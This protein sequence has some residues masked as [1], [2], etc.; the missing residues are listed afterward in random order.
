MLVLRAPVLR[1]TTLYRI[2]EIA[3]YRGMLP[4]TK[5]RLI[6]FL[7]TQRLDPMTGRIEGRYGTDQVDGGMALAE[8]YAWQFGVGPDRFWEDLKGVKA[9]GLAEQVVKPAPGRRAVY[10]LVLR[11]DAI[12][13]DLPEDLMRELRV[14]D[15]PEAE[16][17][18][19][20]AAYGH[21][22]ARPAPA[23]EP[24]VVRGENRET[25]QL[26]TELA[27]APLWEHP[28]DS[29]AAAVAEELRTQWQRASRAVDP[30]PGWEPAEEPQAALVAPA[31]VKPAPAPDLR[32][33]AVADRD[34]AAEM[35]ARIHRL[36][37]VG[38]NGKTSPLYARGFSQ[39]DGFTSNG[40]KWLNRDEEM[41][42]AETTPSAATGKRTGQAFGDDLSSVARS[43]MRRVWH[44][45]RVQLGRGVV[46]LPSGTPE[47]LS[48]S[49]TGDA[50]S[51]LHHTITIALR[52]STESELVDL[53][54][55][56]IVR[57][58]EWGEITFRAENLGRLAGWRLW[59]L[60]NS[61]KNAHGHG[62]RREVKVAAHVQV[63]DEATAEERDRI[64]NR[65]EQVRE[66][67]KQREQVRV[68]ERLAERAE[69]RE[70]WGL[71]RF[72]QPEIRG[73]QPEP[74]RWAQQP[75]EVHLEELAGQRRVPSKSSREAD[76]SWR[77]ALA[78][79]RAE[80]AA[81]KALGGG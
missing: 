14:W 58:N 33:I 22:S 44:S 40:S 32:C 20:D 13:S 54:T 17:P 26:I 50:W 81:R 38:V 12:P 59:K 2:A 51:D 47:E 77:A 79:A 80:K 7:N 57:R 76:A 63:W 68:E 48:R 72:E 73:T 52:R 74:R 43:V 39:L 9:Y 27:A 28:A 75:E 49:M 21:L 66:L 37:A 67:D 30:W 70:R 45:W 34:R 29:P 3:R 23:V 11:A 36:M 8:R 55:S 65:V 56:N 16:D 1:L 69:R 78:K 5:F 15:L 64:R 53:L 18:D 62:P 71:H 60:I 35:T 31:V 61:R 4:E 10:A 24:F 6:K 19:E 25:Q 42:K 46:F 41:E